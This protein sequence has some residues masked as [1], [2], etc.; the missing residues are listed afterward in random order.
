[1]S[2]EEWAV[3]GYQINDLECLSSQLSTIAYPKDPPVLKVLW[4][5]NSV[6]GLNSLRR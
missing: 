4:R 1:M 6:W 5:V 3:A 2:R